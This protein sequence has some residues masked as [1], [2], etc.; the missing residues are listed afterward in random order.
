MH[1][2]TAHVD[3]GIFAV[4]SPG[5]R[6]PFTLLFGLLKQHLRGRR[7]NNNEDVEMIFS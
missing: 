4:F 2:R 7:L 6:A 1:S 5:K 3:K